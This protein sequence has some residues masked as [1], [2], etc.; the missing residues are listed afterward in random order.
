MSKSSS[1]HRCPAPP[2]GPVWPLEEAPALAVVVLLDVVLVEQLVE[3]APFCEVEAVVDAVA[4]LETPPPLGG[5]VAESAAEED[6]QDVDGC[7]E[8]LGTVADCWLGLEVAREGCWIGLEDAGFWSGFEDAR[9]DWR[10]LEERLEV[11]AWRWV[12][13]VVNFPTLCTWHSW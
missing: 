9:E 4:A 11:K 12:D 7:W 5:P 2:I 1:F 8:V 10:G 13:P 6:W 3:E